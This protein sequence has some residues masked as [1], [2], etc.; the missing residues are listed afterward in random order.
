L[1]LCGIACGSLAFHG[2]SFDSAGSSACAGF[3]PRDDETFISALQACAIAAEA[4]VSSA[5]S[6][7]TPLTGPTCNTACGSK[8]VSCSL[9]ADVLSAYVAGQAGLAEAG[10]ASADASADGGEVA[11]CPGIDPTKPIALICTTTCGQ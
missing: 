11:A 3:V 4:H 2:C 9:P 10:G 6:P 5:T 7:F 1:A 8:S